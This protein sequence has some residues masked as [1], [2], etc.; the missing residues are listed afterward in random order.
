MLKKIK[1]NKCYKY[2]LK[3]DHTIECYSY[4]LE[5]VKCDKTIINN[6]EDY[7][8]ECYKYMN[9]SDTYSK[10]ILNLNLLKF[11]IIK[12]IILK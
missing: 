10:R 1:T 8:Q 6:Y 3:K 4:Y 9:S 12:N 7:I 11:I 2:E 5:N